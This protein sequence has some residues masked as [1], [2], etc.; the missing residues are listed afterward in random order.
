MPKSRERADQNVWTILLAGNPVM[1]AC[2]QSGPPTD[3]HEPIPATGETKPQRATNTIAPL[4]IMRALCGR[5][6][7]VLKKII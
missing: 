1:S 2:S 7:P 6:L 4:K 5:I 3:Q